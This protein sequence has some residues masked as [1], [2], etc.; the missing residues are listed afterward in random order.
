MLP[1]AL[2]VTLLACLLP[3]LSSACNDHLFIEPG[4]H[5]TLTTDWYQLGYPGSIG[6]CSYSAQTHY[7]YRI[8]MDCPV[9][10]TYNSYACTVNKLSW[11]PGGSSTILSVLQGVR[12]WC[13]QNDGLYTVTTSNTFYAEFV[14]TQPNSYYLGLSCYLTAVYA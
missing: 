6:K 14:N 3:E 5:Y 10:Q 11:W 12:Y 1:T 4:Q 13:G 8:R 2:L 9:F 7:N